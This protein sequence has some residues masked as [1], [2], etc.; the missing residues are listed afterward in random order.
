[1]KRWTS[2]FV[3]LFC[4]AAAALVASRPLGAQATA[5]ASRSFE[6]SAFFG[7][8]GTYTGLEGSRNLGITAGVDLG[9]HPYFG[10]EP[11]VEVRGTYPAD[12]G[13]V[14]GEESVLAGLRV[15]K[16]YGR[17]RPYADFLVGRGQLN[18]QNGG[19]PVPSQNFEYLQSTTNVFSPGIG[20]EVDVTPHFSLLLDGQYQRWAVPF[21]PGVIPGPAASHIWSTPGTIGVSYR[22]G[23]LVHGHPGP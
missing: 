14:V 17:F 3:A 12:S 4:M 15:Q 1:M 10:L 5:T 8:T 20:V 11:S 9:F 22:F 21:T 18:Y 19:Y 6:P 13:A 2:S 7:I 16:R 23:W